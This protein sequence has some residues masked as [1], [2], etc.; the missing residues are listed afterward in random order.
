MISSIV[1][2]DTSSIL[3]FYKEVGGKKL[4]ELGARL[5][6]PSCLAFKKKKLTFIQINNLKILFY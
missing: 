4:K 6:R 3:F 1:V 2:D 5:L